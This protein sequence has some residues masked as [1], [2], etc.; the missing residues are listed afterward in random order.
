[1]LDQI[2]YGDNDTYLPPGRAYHCRQPSAF[3]GIHQEEE[4]IVFVDEFLQSFDV[5]FRLAY[6]RGRDGVSRH[7][8][9]QFVSHC[10]LKP[11]G[12]VLTSDPRIS[13]YDTRGDLLQFVSCTD[14]F[15]LPTI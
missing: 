4:G 13:T 3:S 10:V 14:S 5:L 1:M 9:R 2:T 7:W 8:D 15:D 12:Q 6:R 11:K